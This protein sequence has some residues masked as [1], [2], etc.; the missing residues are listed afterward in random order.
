MDSKRFD[1]REEGRRVK[2]KTSYR[3]LISTYPCQFY[4]ADLID[5]SKKE[6]GKKQDFER[7]NKGYKFILVVVDAYSRYCWME[8]IKDKTANSIIV[9][10]EKIFNQNV[11]NIA[12]SVDTITLSDEVQNIP[13]FIVTDEGKEFVNS[14]FKAHLDF[15]K[16]KHIILKGQ[17]KAFLAERV[18]QDYKMFVRGRWNKMKWINLTQPFC[19]FYNNKYHSVIKDT[20][21]NIFVEG[22]KPALTKNKL[23]NKDKEKQFNLGDNVRVKIFKDEDTLQKKSL[24]DNWSSSIYNIADI[25]DRYDPIMYKVR[26]QNG[27]QDKRKY[28]HFE[29]IKA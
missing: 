6:W 10:F 21:H 19:D 14:A 25:D 16:I 3:K 13:Q 22:K 20:P 23:M 15:N 5:W 9:A 17:S 27:R 2:N 4:F 29:L 7:A 12:G 1:P 26:D 24:T 18:I 28:Y 11:Y 8:N